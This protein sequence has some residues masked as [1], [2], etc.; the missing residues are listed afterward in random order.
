VPPSGVAFAR[1]PRGSVGSARPR[2][3]PVLGLLRLQVGDA[4]HEL[5]L[6]VDHRLVRL[7]DLLALLLLRH[8]GAH[9][10][11]AHTRHGGA[12]TDEERAR[13]CAVRDLNTRRPRARVRVA[14][15]AVVG[16]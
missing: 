10:G 9:G 1:A 3:G 8:G 7:D 11:G 15:A 14:V 4:L 12:H 6:A 13:V 5:L 2:D 16:S